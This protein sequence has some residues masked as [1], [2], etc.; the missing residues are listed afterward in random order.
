MGDGRATAAAVKEQV[1]R[2]GGGFMRS[3]ETK[4]YSDE[5]GLPGWGPYMRGRCGVLGD[6]DA[7]VV[8]AVIGFFPSAVVRA[9]WESGQHLPAAESASRYAHAC[10]EYG[11]RQL[12][13]FA[14]AARLAELLEAVARQADVTG[15][16]LFAGWRALPLPADAPARALQLTHVLR[17]LRGGRHLVA[18]QATGLTPLEAV[19]SGGSQLYPAGP[20]QA[21]AFG[22]PEPYEEVTDELRA[23][24]AQAEDLTD[25]LSG[26][27]Y[28]VLTDAE[29]SELIALLDKACAIAFG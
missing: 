8:T 15:A 12:G 18:V 2:L 9:A 17:E 7:D 22:W 29:A 23:R 26:P 28:A 4:A 6:V 21:R 16:P 11:R 25:V 20:D 5:L 1:I 3:R 19:L 14:D 10:Q 24:R 27:D 13:G